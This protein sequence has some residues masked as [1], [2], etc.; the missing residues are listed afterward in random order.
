MKALFCTR[1]ADVL[2]PFRHSGQT[3]TW[4][5]CQ[6][7]EAAVRWRDGDRGLLEVAAVYGPSSIR[8]IGVN[9][10]FLGMATAGPSVGEY[11]TAEQWRNMHDY[12]GKTVEP[13]YLFH[14]DKRNCWAVITRIGESGDIFYIDEWPVR[15][16][17]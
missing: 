5:Y 6:C 17:S 10:V 4:R 14:T 12:Q 13:H 7:G 1:C 9:N 11:H 8:V 2:A 15:E 3:E 16:V